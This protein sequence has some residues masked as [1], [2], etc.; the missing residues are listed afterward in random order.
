MSLILRI[1]FVFN[2]IISPDGKGLTKMKGTLVDAEC[3]FE[4]EFG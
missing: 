4:K 3:N 1:N 2:N